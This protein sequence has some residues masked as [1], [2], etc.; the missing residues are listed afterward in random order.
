[1]AMAPADDRLFDPAHIRARLEARTVAR[2]RGTVTRHAAVAAVVRYVREPEVL[3]IRRTEHPGDPWSGHMAFPGGRHEQGDPD[4]RATAVRETREEVGVDL[5]AHAEPLGQLD[6][7]QALGRGAPVD[8]AIV[9]FVFALHTEV[10]LA[11]ND[12]VAEAMWAPLGPMLRGEVAAV[13]PYVW[14]G[15]EVA[16]PAF[17][18]GE[19]LVWGLTYRMLETLF[20]AVADR[21]PAASA[22]EAA[23]VLR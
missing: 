16:L 1:M 13:R 10:A 23:P 17:R 15:K 7:F 5:A 19:H 6:E 9:P 12:E 21:P 4:L 18:V 8:L 2:L 14:H 20:E 3:L 22:V 11:P